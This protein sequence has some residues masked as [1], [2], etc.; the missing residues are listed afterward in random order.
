MI[1]LKKMTK[2]EYKIFI[3]KSIR[4]YAKEGIKIGYWT[5]K[6]AY[7]ESKAQYKRNMGKGYKNASYNFYKVFNNK[8]KKV[9]YLWLA[10]E[11][12]LLFIAE[13]YIREKYRHQGYGRSTL[14]KVEK[15]AKKLKYKKIGLTVATHNKIAQSLYSQ[16]NI[17]AISEFRMK[18]I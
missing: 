10:K 5:K 3:K 4:R 7:K 2:K 16:C 8:H 14:A 6:E 18:R 15:I 12:K 9:G 17:R 13:I 1:K 11:H